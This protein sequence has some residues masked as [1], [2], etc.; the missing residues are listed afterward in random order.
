M[1]SQ[2]LAQMF[3]A[4]AFGA[5]VSVMAAEPVLAESASFDQALDQALQG[6]HR[7]PA[8]RERDK[9]RHPKETLQFFG[10]RPD[11]TVVE[12]S[13]GRGWYTEILAPV[14]RDRG[15]LYAVGFGPARPGL[16]EYAIKMQTAFE[17]KLKARPQ[18][19]DQ[20]VLTSMQNPK[21]ADFAPPG[22]ADMVL[23]FR[24]VHN[25]IADGTADD[26]FKAMYRALKTGGT[27]GVVEHRAKPGTLP[28]EIKKSG[29]VTEDHVVALAEKAGF[30]LADRS[31]INAN[32]KDT[33]DH[34]KGVW[35]LPPNLRMGDQ[36]R[37]RYVAIGESDRM[38]LKFIK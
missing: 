31:E 26:M 34:P 24:N 25:W 1:K 20:V 12:I 14:L 17:A 4:F 32:P 10:L 2:S 33:K 18:F 23:T 13:P 8:N 35:T 7:D 3:T 28:E 29:Y 36:D 9:Y 15:K 5:L 16:P 27:L 37:E 38:T 22:T 11:M 6:D 19:Y 30:K 21:Q